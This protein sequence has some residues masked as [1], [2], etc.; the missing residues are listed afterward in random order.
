MSVRKFKPKEFCKKNLKRIV[1]VSAMGALLGTGATL[2]FFTDGDEK[3][4][5]F[6]VGNITID[7][8][9]PHWNPNEDTDGD[10]VPDR[11]EV[12]PE[13]E[14]AKDPQ[15]KNIGKNP[16]YMFMKITVPYRNIVS[17]DDYGTK[18]SKQDTELWTYDLTSHWIE[19]TNPDETD[20]LQM[21]DTIEEKHNGGKT[22]LGR[23]DTT[24][25]TITH[26]YAYVDDS[27]K[28]MQTV[29]ENITTDPIFNY[30]KFVNAVED[31]GLENNH[32]DIKVTAYAIQTTNVSDQKI[33]T[34]GNNADGKTT[35]DEVYKIL[36]T[37]NSTKTNDKGSEDDQDVIQSVV[38]GAK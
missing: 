24:N 4:N 5:E 9:E 28:N 30:V 12:I 37:Q 18:T 33:A 15:I 32:A 10:G 1:A 2:A 23:K 6:T 11:S 25:Q 21:D 35:P 27:G 3:T 14:F 31:Q 38:A 34:D 7:L 20:G 26:L 16:A 36:T 19:I 29:K 13:Q 17:T 22:G 8:Q